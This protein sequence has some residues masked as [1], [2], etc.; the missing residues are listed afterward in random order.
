[1]KKKLDLYCIFFVYYNVGSRQ[2]EDAYTEMTNDYKDFWNKG[3]WRVVTL[4]E[5]MYLPKFAG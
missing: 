1:M 4:K 3:K 2:W 5:P